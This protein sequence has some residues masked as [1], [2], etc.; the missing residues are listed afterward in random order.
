[1]ITYEAIYSAGVK[2]K[3]QKTISV[4]GES[5]SQTMMFNIPEEELELISTSV[6]FEHLENIVLYIREMASSMQVIH[7]DEPRLDN[8]EFFT[9]MEEIL[10]A[11]DEARSWWSYTR[12]YREPEG[13]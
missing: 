13:S 11:R 6:I 12:L 5:Y 9:N 10:W 2:P 4:G 1:M 7:L 3:L 8:N